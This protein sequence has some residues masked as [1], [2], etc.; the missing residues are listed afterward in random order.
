[1]KYVNIFIIILLSSLLLAADGCL[2]SSDQ[3]KVVGRGIKL[4]LDPDGEL[5]STVYESNP[6]TIK[7][8]VSNYG[9]SP[10]EGYL[11]LSDTPSESY[12]GIRANDCQPVNLDQA[13]QSEGDV[14]PS[15]MEFFF[16]SGGAYSYENLPSQLSQGLTMDTQISAEFSYVTKTI[17]LSKICLKAFNS[18]SKDCTNKETITSIQQAQMPIEV[19]KIEKAVAVSKDNQAMIGLTVYIKQVE[20]GYIIDRSLNSGKT[21]ISPTA[22]LTVTLGNVVLSCTPVEHGDIIRFTTGNEKMIQCTAKEQLSQDLI[23]EPLIITIEY[24]F[25]KTARLNPIQLIK[26]VI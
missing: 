3:G 21:Q 7:A 15:Q 8:R 22:K 24:G 1:M 20:E 10:I 26:E 6:F 14:K 13:L 18:V 25:K 17:A 23:N 11:C 16:P 9:L 12:G 4:E 2:V 19:T 5:P